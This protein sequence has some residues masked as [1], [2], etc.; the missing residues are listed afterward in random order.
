MF[1]INKEIDVTKNRHLLLRHLTF[2][3]RWMCPRDAVSIGRRWLTYCRLR[4]RQKPS[5]FVLKTE[6]HVPRDLGVHVRFHV[7]LQPRGPTQTIISFHEAKQD[8]VRNVKHT[9]HREETDNTWSHLAPE[10]EHLWL[11]R[12]L[13]LWQSWNSCSEKKKTACC[14]SARRH[15]DKVMARPYNSLAR[16]SHCSDQ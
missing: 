10:G 16:P 4:S 2:C 13:L 6:V 11:L 3:R 7:A 14:L 5:T 12:G 15:K 1:C 9:K 8:R